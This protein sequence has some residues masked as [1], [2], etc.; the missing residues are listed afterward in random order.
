MRES[1]WDN[2]KFI[3]IY[4][5]VLGH[6]LGCCTT[7]GLSIV[8]WDFVYLFHIPLFVFISGRFSNVQ[9]KNYNKGILN[10]LFV[11]ILFHIIRSGHGIITAHAKFDSLLTPA[12]TLWYLLTL[13]Y[14]RILVKF[15][16]QKD[17]GIIIS[18]AFVIGI[19]AGFIPIS[20]EMSFQRTFCYLPLFLL[21]YY[22]KNLDLQTWV[23]RIPR[24]LSIGGL[25]III[26]SLYV[27]L[28]DKDLEHIVTGSVYYTQ[29][30]YALYRFLMYIAAFVSG[31]FIMNITPT[32]YS[33]ISKY[34]Q[35]TMF[36]FLYHS[37]I[38][39]AIKRFSHQHI[40]N[41]DTTLAIILSIAIMALM[42]L[43]LRFKILRQLTNPITFFKKHKKS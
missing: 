32:K 1:Y 15:L 18:T 27:F 12:Y 34:G 31:L 6:C 8:F 24:Y 41:I 13:V 23:K 3:L 30:T 35:Q 29:P 4:C 21:G 26:L 14:W 19:L 36:I 28:R 22:T 7:H 20:T 10:L 16:P 9:S 25:I 39:R 42:F 2:L 38:I 43:L 11:Y 40:I 33:W 17:N 37:F 5:V